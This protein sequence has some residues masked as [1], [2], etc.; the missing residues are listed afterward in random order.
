MIRYLILFLLHLQV[1]IIPKIL[2]ISEKIETCF[3]P[4]QGGQNN[5]DKIAGDRIKQLVTKTAAPVI[6]MIRNPPDIVEEYKYCLFSYYCCFLE[7][8]NRNSNFFFFFFAE[9]I[10]VT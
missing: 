5:A 10:M 7:E 1:F 2:E 8:F 3:Q 6:K 9:M 4:N